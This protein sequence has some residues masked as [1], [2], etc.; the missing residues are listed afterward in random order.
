[1]KI[2]PES[3]SFARLNSIEPINRLRV[4]SLADKISSF[5]CEGEQCNFGADYQEPLGVAGRAHKMGLLV[6]QKV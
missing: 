3:Y 6:L 4:S 5:S 2:N 1:M